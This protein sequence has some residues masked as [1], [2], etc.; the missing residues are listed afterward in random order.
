MRVPNTLPAKD[1]LGDLTTASGYQIWKILLLLKF[2]WS[3]IRQVD[4]LI[5]HH[6]CVFA[7]AQPEKMNTKQKAALWF[8]ERFNWLWIE[9]KEKKQMNQ[10]KELLPQGNMNNWLVVL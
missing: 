2:S 4:C 5:C 6:L 10:T 7:Q 9:L 8:E 3:N 1:L